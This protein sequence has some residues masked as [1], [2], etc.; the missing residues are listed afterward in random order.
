MSDYK[1]YTAYTKYKQE[2]LFCN[3]LHLKGFESYLPLDSN[4]NA[5]FSCYVF[6]HI[7]ESS[8]H[9][10]RNLKGFTRWVSFGDSPSTIPH[11][12]IESMQRISE[13]SESLSSQS[14]KL[15]KG[16]EVRI[17]KGPLRGIVGKLVED[18]GKTKLAME[19]S[20]LNQAMMVTV[21]LDWVLPLEQKREKDEMTSTP[22]IGEVHVEH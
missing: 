18:Q 15:V 4:G 20:Q 6:V 17:I 21:P 22:A 16:D 1:W 10:V 5:L 7:P 8:L 2:L 19:I 14:S 11:D 9:Q 12:Q 13:F 3:A